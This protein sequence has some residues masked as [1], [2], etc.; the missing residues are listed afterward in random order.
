MTMK[1]EFFERSG[2]RYLSTPGGGLYKAKAD[3]RIIFDDGAWCLVARLPKNRDRSKVWVNCKLVRLFNGVRAFA[4]SV[5]VGTAA[6]EV[7]KSDIVRRLRELHPGACE[8]VSDAALKFYKRPQTFGPISAPRV[9]E[10]TTPTAPLPSP[11]ATKEEERR[12]VDLI[13]KR[14][15]PGDGL[16]LSQRRVTRGQWRYVGEVGE[17]KLGVPEDI[18]HDAVQ[19]MLTYGVVRDVMLDSR[20]RRRGLVVVETAYREYFGM[21]QRS[22]STADAGKEPANAE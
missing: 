10:P 4:V 14:M 20:S 22:S 7:A 17:A 19:K 11:Q 12:I 1:C 15:E 16:P 5:D 3:D 9:K 18:V 13:R 6:G 21:P 2:S 8:W